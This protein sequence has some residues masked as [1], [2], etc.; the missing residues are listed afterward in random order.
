MKSLNKNIEKVNFGDYIKCINSKN[1]NNLTEGKMYKVLYV[2][3]ERKM[4]LI[5]DDSE[6]CNNFYLVR[7]TF[8]YKLNRDMVIKEILE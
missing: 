7:F 1:Q 3:T 6:M 2:S 5:S 8:D 4:V